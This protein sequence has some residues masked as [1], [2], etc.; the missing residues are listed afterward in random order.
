MQWPRLRKWL[1][2]IFFFLSLPF[3]LLYLVAG[4]FMLFFEDDAKVFFTKKLNEQL[5][6]EVKIEDIN[7]SLL[8]KFPFATI[9]LKNVSANEVV[10]G[11]K[12]EKL[13]VAGRIYCLFNWF[14][15]F[16]NNYHL[17]QIELEDVSLNLKRFADGTDNFHFWKEVKGDTTKSAPINI[18][19]TQVSFKNLNLLYTDA[20]NNTKLNLTVK[21]ATVAGEFA[22]DNYTLTASA[23][24]TV[25]S[26]L[27]GG[28]VIP[29]S[30]RAKLDVKAQVDNK[31]QTYSFTNAL[32]ELGNLKLETSGSIKAG[33]KP[34]IEIAVK[35]K[36][37]DVQA[38]LSA[39]PPN[40]AQY[41]TDYESQGRFYIDG[42]IK[43]PLANPTTSAT[44][45]ING[46]TIIHKP[47]NTKLS[48]VNFTGTFFSDN[49]P[50]NGK[51]NLNN[52]RFT[53]PEGT[54]TGQ[55]K[56]ENLN[57]PYITAQVKGTANLASLR[58]F[59][60]TDEIK[61]M[62]GVVTADVKL[63]G[64]I[65]ELEQIAQGNTSAAEGSII[66]KNGELDL[67]SYH[68]VFAG[69]TGSATFANSTA[70]LNQLSFNIGRSSFVFNGVVD[71]FPTCLLNK[72]E[73][74][75]ITARLYSPYVSID[76]LLIAPI[77]DPLKDTAY[78]F[79]LSERFEANLAVEVK[80]VDFR[81]F[82][83]TG[84]T[85]NLKLYNRVIDLSGVRL[86]TANGNVSMTA[87]IDARSTN[88]I[89]TS[90]EAQLDNIDIHRLF[91][92]FENFGQT[93][94]QSKHIKGT[95]SASVAYASNWN[96]N[97][98]ID[99]GSIIAESDVQIVNG[100]LVNF[101]P[102]SAMSRF[103][104]VDE[105]KDIRF[106]NLSNHIIIRDKLITIPEMDI[107][108]NVLRLTGYG[109][110]TFDNVMDYHVKVGLRELLSKKFLKNKKPQLDANG[111]AVEDDGKGGVNLFLA[112][113]G[114]AD[115]P[116]VRYDTKAVS[117]KIKQDIQNEKVNLKKI[118][119]NE[120]SKKN[121]EGEQPAETPEEDNGPK[122]R[123]MFKKKK[124]KPTKKAKKTTTPAVE[125]E[126][127]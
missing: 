108:S 12:K 50:E 67:K 124:D 84:L 49:K 119:K 81:R 43:G 65:G 104:N 107:Q 54:V 92:E 40:I 10:P 70:T 20:P 74:V 126:E 44:F 27:A 100:S 51:L 127:N 24:L 101:E 6:T 33:K 3:V 53:L 96:K 7:F 69:V 56:L 82:T 102:A 121:K 105:L 32:I 76:E 122:L 9:E 59:I 30:A 47:S 118:F 71:N 14:D 97:L 79:T 2:R 15:M 19:L 111:E 23:D 57:Q 37:L 87:H 60:P 99:F 39:L 114:T 29:P 35:G 34:Y 52:I 120:F 72:N 36:D 125:W 88:I 55:F 11:D 16:D 42:L 41:A 28:Y 22:D 58:H 8:K 113:S 75:R 26:L 110:H 94:L 90:C 116:K 5:L 1:T 93:T 46:A 64:Y 25:N 95:L 48:N 78:V 4:I 13:L 83:G 86:N 66:L 61:S 18:R 68:H 17:K 73:K 98:E 45:G 63:R 31:S 123:D 103:I 117:A 109:T 89:R 38:V 112:I 21:T 62:S 91:Y 77:K 85:A 80:Q 106:S 115:D